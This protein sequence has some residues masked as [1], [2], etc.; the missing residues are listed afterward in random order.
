MIKKLKNW[1]SKKKKDEPKPGVTPGS[2][3]YSFVKSYEEF[4]LLLFNFYK[5][6]CALDDNITYIEPQD[7]LFGEMFD[8]AIRIKILTSTF[9]EYFEKVD[10]DEM[11]ARAKEEFKKD[12]EEYKKLKAERNGNTE[13]K[14]EQA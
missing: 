14:D 7:S 1:F 11:K 4:E 2:G 13:N 6:G 10:V 3:P 8:N 5:Q 9:P 12:F